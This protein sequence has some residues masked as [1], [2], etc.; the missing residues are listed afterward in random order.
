MSSEEAET[1]ATRMAAALRAQTGQEA[2]IEVRPDSSEMG[3][4]SLPVT[5]IPT[6]VVTI[7]PRRQPAHRIEA[8]LRDED[9]PILVRVHESQLLI[10]PRTLGHDEVDLVV[11]RLAAVLLEDETAGSDG[12]MPV[13]EGGERE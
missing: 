3:G 13:V 4:G 12:T 9:P 11:S 6:S 10:D 7:H 2:K 8:R 5:P 1:V